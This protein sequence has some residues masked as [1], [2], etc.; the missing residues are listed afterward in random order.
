M[1]TSTDKRREKVIRGVVC[2][3]MA[4]YQFIDQLI[5]LAIWRLSSFFLIQRPV[6]KYTFVQ[7]PQKAAWMMRIPLFFHLFSFCF[8]FLFSLRKSVWLV[9]I[10]HLL[11]WRWSDI[12]RADSESDISII[13][14]IIIFFF[15]LHFDFLKIWTLMKW[16]RIWIVDHRVI[17][18]AGE[19]LDSFSW[20]GATTHQST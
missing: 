9:F 3:P 12:E 1:K 16:C 14:S 20:L 17:R 6:E 10:L 15:L 5:T 4:T 2:I 13:N 8:Y 7:S 18:L 11:R 19:D